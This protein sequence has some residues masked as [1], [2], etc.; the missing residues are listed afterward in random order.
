MNEVVIILE[1]FFFIF[2]VVVCDVCS[3]DNDDGRDVL[4]NL[5]YIITNLDLGLS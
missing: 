3:N 5:L 4:F 2:Y 1:C